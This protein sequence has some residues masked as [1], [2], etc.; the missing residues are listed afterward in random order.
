MVAGNFDATQ[1]PQITAGMCEQVLQAVAGSEIEI[2]KNG[3]LYVY[4][5]NES[6]GGLAFCFITLNMHK[7]SFTICRI[8]DKVCI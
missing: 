1:I 6:Q 2:K 7:K 8:A 4:V 5:S 3:Y